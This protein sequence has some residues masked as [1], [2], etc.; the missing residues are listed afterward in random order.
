LDEGLGGG[1]VQYRE[2]QEHESPSFVALFKNRGGL[3][4]LP[5]GVDSGF[6]KVDR[7]AYVTRLLMV[8][9]K[10]TVR[11]REVPLSN[12]SLNTGDVFILDAGLKIYIWNGQDANRS[13][14]SKGIEVA[15]KIRNEER[16]A[17]A[18][19]IIMDEE[20]NNADFW[21]ALGGQITVTNPGD[22]DSVAD[23]KTVC[24]RSL[25]YL[26]IFFFRRLFGECLTLGDLSRS[27]KWSS[28]VEN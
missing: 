23:S 26:L 4:Y 22:P 28:Q 5:G 7:D 12:A 27:L 20:P 3:E 2:V 8:K 21:S 11:V 14:K 10:R 17:R 13:E 9:G 24:L 15:S 19:I 16:G 1:P 25:F 18:E 6:R